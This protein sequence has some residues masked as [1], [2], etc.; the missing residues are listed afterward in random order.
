MKIVTLAVT[1][2]FV[3]C[4]AQMHAQNAKV[5][6]L[7]EFLKGIL[8]LEQ[9]N[10]NLQEPITTVNV[11]AAKNADK[12]IV[13]TKDNIEEALKEAQQYKSNL[14]TIDDHTIVRITDFSKCSPSGA[15]SACMP[16]GEGYIQ[17]DELISMKDYI[18]YIIG[19]P[20]DQVRTLYL[21]E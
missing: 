16:Y 5:E 10:I 15:W 11:I 14:I 19:R 7:R 9:G 18:N 20:D 13:L 21:F 3:M 8:T 6:T 1:A 2:V 17:K 4:F 12:T